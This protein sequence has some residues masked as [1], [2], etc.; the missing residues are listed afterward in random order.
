MR[1]EVGKQGFKNKQKKKKTRGKKG[2]KKETKKEK[3]GKKANKQKKTNKAWFGSF[4][5]QG[6]STQLHPSPA[7]KQQR[8]ST[9]CTVGLGAFPF[10]FCCFSSLLFLQLCSLVQPNAPPE[11]DVYTLRTRGGHN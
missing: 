7:Q 9:D 10:G 11:S 6:L 8:Q 1:S 4:R 3:T 2:R 5:E